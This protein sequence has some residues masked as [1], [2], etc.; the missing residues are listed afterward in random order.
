MVESREQLDN[1]VRA[2][3]ELTRIPEMRDFLRNHLLR[4]KLH[5]RRWDYS[6]EPVLYP[7]WLVADLGKDDVGIVYS[8]YG[9]GKHDPWGAVLIS[10]ER[11][12]MDDRWFLTIEDAI[13]NS[14]CWDGSIPDDYE[15]R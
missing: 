9:H 11:F 13:I 6:R 1:L 12:G 8:E 3:M 2:E 14:G 4:P 10:D 5:Y 7:C 15:G